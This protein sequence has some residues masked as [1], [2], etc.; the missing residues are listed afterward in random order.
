MTATSVVE[1]LQIGPRRPAGSPEDPQARHDGLG[2]AGPELLPLSAGE[3]YRFSFAMEACVGCHSCEVACAEQNGLPADTAWRRVGEIEGGS[4]PDTTRFHLSMSCN[5]CLDP[6]CL[7]GCPTEAYVKLDNGVVAHHAD[8]CIGCQYCTWNC[9]YSVPAFQP[10]RRIVTKCDMCLPRLEVGLK[11]ACVGACPT[12]ALDVEVVD[13]AAWTADHAEADAPHLP[14]SEL[15]LSTTR[16]VLPPGEWGE[17]A[18]ASDVDLHP[19]H[20]HWPLVVLTLLTQVALGVSLTATDETSRLAAAVLAAGALAGSLLHLGRPAHAWK[21]LRNLRRSWLSREVLLLGSYAG[22]AAVAVPVAPLAPL[23]AFVGAAG[24]YASGRL[25]VVPGRPSWHSP[26]TIVAFFLTALATGPLVTGHPAV[27]AGAVG[28]QLA[29]W[30]ANLVRLGRDPR[31]EWNG[32]VAL[33][34]HRFGWLTAARWA[35]VVG[36]AALAFTSLAAGLA[37]VV[38]GELIGRYLFYVTVV[39]LDIPGSFLGARRRC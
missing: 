8:D 33:H 36:G 23:A 32:T 19:E 30:L 17:T 31:R 29:V 27:A 15:T 3:Q 6:A 37:L 26:L 25:Y 5:H 9:P 14:P 11:P 13:V 7:T 2:A 24:V 12:R 22:M 39:P 28:G 1:G 18:A 20:P 21:A 34:R 35:S 4:Y 16:I 10:D 38:A